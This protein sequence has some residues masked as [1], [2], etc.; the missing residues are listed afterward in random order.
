MD[1]LDVLDYWQE[2]DE[3]RRLLLNL[4]WPNGVACPRCGNLH[5]SWITTR[6]TFDCLACRYVFSVTAGTTL[7][8]THIPLSKWFVATYLMCVSKKGIPAVQLARMLRISDQAAWYLGHRVRHAM[9]QTERIFG[10]IVEVDETYYGARN[11]KSIV[12]GI[13]QRG[14]GTYLKVTTDRSRRT[15]H[16]FV[17][18]AIDPE[19]VEAVFSDGWPGYN[20][21]PYH[22]ASNHSKRYYGDSYMHTN[23]IEG[24]WSLLK[25]SMK[26]IFHFVQPK[27]LDYYIDELAWKINNR[28]HPE[29]WTLTLQRLVASRPLSYRALTRPQLVIGN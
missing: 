20:G 29:L 7:H 14:G 22:M 8:K 1:L 9:H 5:I 18:E 21:L 26:G 24:I 11:D 6:G 16:K 4:R 17:L 13:V 25:R 28:H 2:E 15:L 19:I 23:T 10:G 27:Y 3:C 12:L